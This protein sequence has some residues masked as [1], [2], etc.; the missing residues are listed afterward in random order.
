MGGGG[1]VKSGVRVRCVKSG[2][3]PKCNGEKGDDKRVC[4]K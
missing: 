1:G 2:E 3:G 4:R